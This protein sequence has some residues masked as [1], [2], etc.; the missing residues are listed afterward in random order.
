MTQLE[1]YVRIKIRSTLEVG[2]HSFEHQLEAD[3]SQMELNG[4]VVALNENPEVHDILVQLPL[5]VH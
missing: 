5:P 2:M 3:V 4:L 1:V